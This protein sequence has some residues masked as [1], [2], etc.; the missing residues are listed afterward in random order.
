M[1][2]LQKYG[3]KI[4]TRTGMVLENLTVQARDRSEA[5]RRIQ[6]IYHYCE[7]LECHENTPTARAGTADVDA[8]IALINNTRELPELPVAVRRKRDQPAD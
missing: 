8:V 5:E 6:Q 4:K 2:A 7:V 3:F 1:S